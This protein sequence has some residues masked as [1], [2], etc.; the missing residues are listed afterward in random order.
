MLGGAADAGDMNEVCRVLLFGSGFATVYSGGRE[1]ISVCNVRMHEKE[2]GTSVVMATS[3]SWL[4]GK[5]TFYG[6]K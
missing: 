3:W 5:N 1:C 6:A 2:A 4:I